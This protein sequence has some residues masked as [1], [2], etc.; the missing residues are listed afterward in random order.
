MSCSFQSS[1][2]GLIV[3]FQDYF[4]SPSF[5]IL[6]QGTGPRHFTSF[7][8]LLDD[9]RNIN[10]ID[11]KPIVTYDNA[12]VDKVKIF[13]DNRNKSGVYRWINNKNG[14]TYVGSS[15]NLTRRLTNYFSIGYLL[16][17]SARSNSYLYRALL[18]YGYSNFSFRTFTS[19]AASCQPVDFSGSAVKIYENVYLEKAQIIKENKR[20]AGVYR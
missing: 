5:T 9:N 8:R 14:N 3:S 16:R 1:Q 18:K 15:I 19:S 20:K 2:L 7:C 11:I 17:E 10:F 4:I 6:R 12:D 13:A